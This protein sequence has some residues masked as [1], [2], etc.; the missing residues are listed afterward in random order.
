[1]LRDK[2]LLL[3]LSAVA[4]IILTILIASRLYKPEESKKITPYNKEVKVGSTRVLAELADTPEKRNLGLSGRNSLGANEGMLFVF[5]KKDTRPSFWMEGMLISI[6]II[7][8]DDGK[9]SQLDLNVP[10][11]E[12]DTPSNELPLYKPSVGIDYVLE[13]NAGFVKDKGIAVSDNVD[14]SGILE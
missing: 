13:V 14:V 12:P 7:W 5:D 9:V 11:P 2:K 1:M 6:D 3:F 10:P 4:V 8:I